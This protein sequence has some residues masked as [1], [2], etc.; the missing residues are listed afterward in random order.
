[1]EQKHK[2]ATPTDNTPVALKVGGNHCLVQGQGWVACKVSR[3]Q[4]VERHLKRG[5]QR[6]CTVIH[7]GILQQGR[8][9][10]HTRGVSMT[11]QT[12][13]DAPE[14]MAL[15]ASAQ[16]AGILGQRRRQAKRAT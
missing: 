16:A 7:A 14:N 15:L 3:G 12:C 8:L 4:Q 5:R 2:E 11:S 6:A 9:K 1:M 10:A 13:I